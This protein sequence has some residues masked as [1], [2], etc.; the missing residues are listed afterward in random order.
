LDIASQ[1]SKL[2]G[3]GWPGAAVQA[4][5]ERA[6]TRVPHGSDTREREGATAGMH[7]PEEKV[8]F[9]EYAKASRNDLAEQ[10]GGDLQGGA[11][12]C[13]RAGSAGPP[14]R[15]DFK[16]KL[17]FKFQMNLDFGKTL[18]I[19]IKRFRRNLCMRI[20]PKFF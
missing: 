15:G 9:G 10:G 11:G 18:R 16:W 6:D 17:I 19:S 4:E 14:Y 3:V 8:P 12:W 7:K 5:E 2:G 1:G 13:G 20:F